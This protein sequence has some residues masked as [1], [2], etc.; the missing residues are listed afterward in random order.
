V[1]EGEVILPATVEIVI[2]GEWQRV[3]EFFVGMLRLIGIIEFGMIGDQQ[4]VN[5]GVEVVE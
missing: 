5:I 2:P 4:H 3:A 1:A